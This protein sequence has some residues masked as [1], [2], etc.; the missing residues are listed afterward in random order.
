MEEEGT[1]EV[2]RMR[3]IRLNPTR[4]QREKLKQFADA[5]RFTYNATRRVL[6]DC[7]V[8]GTDQF[9][10]KY[11]LRN[12]LVLATQSLLTQRFPWLLLTPKAIRQAACFKAVANFKS[13]RTRSRKMGDNKYITGFLT[14]K[15]QASIGWTIGVEDCLTLNGG[16]LS[17]LPRSLGAMK[18]YGKVPFEGKAPQQ[19][20]IQKTCNGEYYLCV[21]VKVQIPIE[22]SVDTKPVIALDPGARKF[23]TGYSS[24]GSC[25]TVGESF[26]GRISKLFKVLDT[27][28]DKRKELYGTKRAKACTKRMK[29]LRRKIRDL[30]DEMHY[31]TTNWLSKN[32]SVVVIPNFS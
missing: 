3:K 27:L 4:I 24:D 13:A 15:M 30:R 1:K 31:K 19:C 17:I 11:D 10:T 8:K 18:Y 22:T 6:L 32:F 21:P 12:Q 20:E 14:K 5:Y 7:F 26:A 16:V 2:S 29:R 25:F 28:Q 23:M 9:P